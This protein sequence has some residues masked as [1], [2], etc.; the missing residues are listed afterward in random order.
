MVKPGRIAPIMRPRRVTFAPMYFIRTPRE[1]ALM[2]ET[3]GDEYRE[4]MSRSGRIVPGL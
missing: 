4:Y 3:F 2:L 1:E